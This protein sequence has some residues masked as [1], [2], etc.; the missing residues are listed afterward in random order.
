MGGSLGKGNRTPHAE[1]NIF[2]D[3]EAAS[4][5]LSSGA[6]LVMMGL[7]VTLQVLLDDEK[8]KHYKTLSSHTAI[9]F[10]D[11]MSHYIRACRL[12]GSEYPA[13]HD[14]CCIAYVADPTIFEVEKHSIRVELIDKETYGKTTSVPLVE[15]KSVLVGKKADTS[16]FWPLLDRAFSNLP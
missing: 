4:I 1:F 5:V 2:A 7:D 8:E 9:M 16:K 14:P 3:P 10:N 13:M 15:E 12:H 6:P 11:S